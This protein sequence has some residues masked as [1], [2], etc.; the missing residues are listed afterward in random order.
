M[1]AQLVANDVSAVP[2]STPCCIRNTEI[3]KY[4]L[5]YI[6]AEGNSPLKMFLGDQMKSGQG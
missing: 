2:G 4:I 5:K 3:L 1:S 6:S